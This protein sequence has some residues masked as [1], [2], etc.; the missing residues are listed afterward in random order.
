MVIRLPA[1][2]CGFC[3]GDY[4]ATFDPLAFDKGGDPWAIEHTP[5]AC[6]PS[7]NMKPRQY[8]SECVLKRL[9]NEKG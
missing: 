2:P 4:T 8:V 5:I 3:S 9:R 7:R 6:I 1:A